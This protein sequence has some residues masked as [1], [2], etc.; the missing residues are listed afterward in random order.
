MQDG[1]VDIVLS[2]RVLVYGVFAQSECDVCEYI[3][4]TN[5]SIVNGDPIAFGKKGG[6]LLAAKEFF[7]YVSSAEGQGVWIDNDRLPINTDS[8]D[9]ASGLARPD[10]EQLY[11]D[12]LANQGID[13]KKKI[14]S[15]FKT[16]LAQNDI[17]F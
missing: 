5:G 9:T 2:T 11:Y 17:T 6:N 16:L 14:P 10:V 3:I 15:L 1:E 13:S 8:F 12:T 7:K 4:P